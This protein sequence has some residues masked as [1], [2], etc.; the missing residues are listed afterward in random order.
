[1]IKKSVFFVMA[2]LLALGACQSREGNNEQ[3]AAEDVVNQASDADVVAS[4]VQEIYAAVFKV[5]NEEDS[6]RN[7]DIQME[8]DSWKCRDKFN[9]DFC[10]KEWNALLAKV[11]EIDSLYHSGELG[12]WEADYWIM[13]QDW[14]NLSISDVKVVSVDEKKAVVEFQLHNFDSAQTVRV[15]MVNEDGIWKIDSFIDQSG[16]DWKHDLEEYVKQ[17]ERSAESKNN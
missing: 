15:N 9:H 1:M 3:V 12:F 10:S 7:L 17:E 4:R 16:C 5:Y 14:H 6:L 2:L 8:N 13:G 11:N